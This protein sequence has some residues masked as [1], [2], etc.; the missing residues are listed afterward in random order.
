MLGQASAYNNPIRTVNPDH[1]PKITNIPLNS[2][3]SVR[4]R[5]DFTPTVVAFLPYATHMT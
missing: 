1:Q 2:M 3:S 5:Y 4:L